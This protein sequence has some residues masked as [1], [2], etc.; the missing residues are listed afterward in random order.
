M[1]ADTLRLLALA[2][3]ILIAGSMDFA[4]LVAV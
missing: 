3:L 2:A 1:T 4:D